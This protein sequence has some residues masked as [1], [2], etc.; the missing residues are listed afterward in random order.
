MRRRIVEADFGLH[1]RAARLRSGSTL[2]ALAVRSGVSLTS[3]SRF[4]AGV[5][6]PG[7]A[8]VCAIAQALGTPLLFLADGRDRTGSDPRDLIAHLGY[9]GLNDLAPGE[10]SLFGEARPLEGLI[11]VSL[12]EAGTPRILE[13]I[14]A[15]LLKN[16]FTVIELEAQATAV[17][18]LHRLGWLAELAEWIAGQLPVSRIHPSASAKVRQVREAAWIRRQQDFANTSKPSRG[19]EGWDLFGRTNPSSD[20]EAFRRLGNNSPVA[21]KWRIA[22]AT[23]QEDFLA[24]ARDILAVPEPR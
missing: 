12:T 6:Q 3:L 18:V 5:R 21:Q 16:D 1:L 17:R 23:P 7:F 22:Y 4:E 15:L 19:V 14:P 13:S 9:W 8:D 10:V 2:S 24:R 20:K 11:A